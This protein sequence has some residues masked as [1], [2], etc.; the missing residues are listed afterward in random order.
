MTILL[1]TG[2]YASSL[3]IIKTQNVFSVVNTDFIS[4]NCAVFYYILEQ[5]VIFLREVGEAEWT[6]T[7]GAQEG[8]Y[9]VVGGG[10]ENHCSTVFLII[11][12]S[13][14]KD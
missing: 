2:Y 13:V 1:L 10:V 14:D 11:I 12:L 5:S 6:Q 8:G 9:R 7:F 3:P 4:R